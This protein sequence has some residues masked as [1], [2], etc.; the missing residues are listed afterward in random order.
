MQKTVCRRQ[1]EVGIETSLPFS[2]LHACSSRATIADFCVVQAGKR[3]HVVQA[4]QTSNG[5]PGAFSD[6]SSVAVSNTGIA[7]PGPPAGEK[8]FSQTR[9]Q[10]KDAEDANR[11][12]GLELSGRPILSHSCQYSQPQ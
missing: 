12:T 9:P 6:G 10:S 7:S 8:A 5:L 2:S 4:G 11:T 1:L 3:H